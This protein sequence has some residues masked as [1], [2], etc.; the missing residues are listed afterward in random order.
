MALADG[1]AGKLP[2][3]TSSAKRDVLGRLANLLDRQGIDVDEIGRIQ[4]IS[5]YQSL[6]KNSET[7]EAEIHDL[8]AIQ[9]SPD[10]KSVV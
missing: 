2:N 10:R 4:R 3:E 7:N 1:V 6:T 9:F 8:A 5:V